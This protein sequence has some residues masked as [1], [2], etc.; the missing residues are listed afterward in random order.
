MK[1]NNMTIPL[2]MKAILLFMICIIGLYGNPIGKTKA[3][4]ER[5]FKE[6]D[7]TAIKTLNEVIKLEPAFSEAHFRLGFLYHK[8]N[9]KQEATA[10][11]EATLKLQ[12]CHARALNNL[13]SLK[14]DENKNSEAGDLYKKAITCD[15]GFYSSYYNLANIYK[16]QNENEKAIL[17]YEKCLSL[18]PMHGRSLHN[19]GT[20]YLAGSK[21]TEDSTRTIYLKKAEE[22]V[23]K[24][25]GIL[26]EDPLCRYTLGKIYAASNNKEEAVKALQDGYRLSRAGSLRE[27]IRSLLYEVKG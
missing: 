6:D 9:R 8:M 11:Y 27:K 7:I 18:N 16:D 10:S 14:L 5:S 17:Y 4:Y 23:K 20:L 2:M 13:G 21:N 15:P 1:N 3:L 26:K 12:P 25:C 19:L 22:N 24:A